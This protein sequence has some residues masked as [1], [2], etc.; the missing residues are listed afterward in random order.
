MAT[1]PVVSVRMV[2]VP[3]TAGTVTGAR[4]FV[5]LID[6]APL[7][8]LP[9]LERTIVTT[10]PTTVDALNVPLTEPPGL[11]ATGELNVHPD[12]N[13][14]SILPVAGNE[15]AVVRLTTAVPVRSV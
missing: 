6:S 14:T 11:V 15:F 7:T 12:G 4:T 3:W 10:W 1:P 8:A 2:Y 9:V 5:R 13:V